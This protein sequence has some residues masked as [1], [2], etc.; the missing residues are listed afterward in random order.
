MKPQR[1]QRPLHRLERQ[2]PWLAGCLLLSAVLCGLITLVAAG[3][4]GGRNLRGY[5]P[6]GL[7]LGLLAVALTVLAFAYMLRKRAWQEQMPWPRWQGTMA[8][9]LWAHVYLGLLALLAAVLHAGS[10]LISANLSTGKLLFLVFAGLVLSGLAWRLIYAAVPPTAARDI[11]NYSPADPQQ[12]AEERLLQIEKIAAGKTAEFHALKEQMIHNPGAA[13]SPL[14][15]HHVSRITHHA[16]GNTHYTPSADELAALDEIQKL[17]ASRQRALQRLHQQPLYHFIL[18]GWRALH[19]PLI[20]LFALGLVAHLV[21]VFDLPA[22]LLPAQLG[23]FHPSTECSD[24]HQAIVE[25]W[26]NSMHAH[27]LTSPVTIVQTN[28]VVNTNLAGQRSPDPLLFCNNCHGPVGAKLTE[29]ATLPLNAPAGFDVAA[30]NE[31]ITCTV[32]HQFEGEPVSGGGGLA[33]VFQRELRPGRVYFGP[34]ADPVGNA[35]HQGQTT[36]TWNRPESLCQNCHN[37]NFDLNEDGRIEPG[38][39]LI[40]QTTYDEFE[41]Y[42]AAG[43]RET[44]VT[45]HMPL[46]SGQTRVAETAAIPLQQDYPAPPRL[47]RDHSFVG[48]DY[49]LDTVADADPQQ[50]AREVLL[51]SAAVVQVGQLFLDVGEQNVLSFDVSVTN[52]NLGHHLPTG[53][54]FARQ[55]WLEVVVRDDDGDVLF[56][57]GLLDSNTADLCDADTLDDRGNPMLPYV[58]GC[59]SSDPQLVNF[60]QKLVDRIAL[61]NGNIIQAGEETWLQ[62]LDGGAVARTRPVDGQSLT[63]IPTNETRIFLYQIVL[64]NRLPAAATLTVRLLFRNLPP[65]FLRALADHQPAGE[66][67]QIASLIGNVQIVEMATSE[68]PLDLR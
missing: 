27:A 25:Q 28:Q 42:Q 22:R 39:D 20:V 6:L 10:G 36:P 37:V 59:A 50:E 40:L 32:C 9:W 17:A 55:M 47:V 58:Q 41:V 11:R 51:R 26:A 21:A 31:G 63:R 13:H 67:P 54:A 16:S 48:V 18:Q 61:V 65:Y 19:L 12:Q 64:P 49:P 2:S 14:A 33:A 34:L 66:Q 45:C 29:Q 23:G 4:L 7:L 62:N 43:G 46:I 44:C 56:E 24:C 8:M 15:N 3:L 1:I 5:T 30:I 57:S 53:F 60:Q 52:N 35:F 38:V 68:I